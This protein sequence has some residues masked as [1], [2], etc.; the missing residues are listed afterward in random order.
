MKITQE[1]AT[2]V[3]ENLHRK[4]DANGILLHEIYRRLKIEMF[5]TDNY[6]GYI[7][8]LHY[9]SYDN[10]KQT[11]GYKDV[12]IGGTKG[13]KFDDAAKELAAWIKLIK[14]APKE[15]SNDDTRRQSQG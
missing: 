5:E 3:V 15:G 2:S 14:H 6:D 7:L 9:H 4:L 8:V 1:R 12:R 10:P 13:I 11:I